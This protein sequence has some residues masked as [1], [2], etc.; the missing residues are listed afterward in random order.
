[1]RI[2][3]LLLFSALLTQPVMSY[4]DISTHQLTRK[5]G[6][7]IHYYIDK[8]GEQNKTLL[9]LLQ[10]SDCNSI[11]DNTFIQETFGQWLPDSD[12]LMVEKYGITAQLPYLKNYD[13][14]KDCPLE[15]MLKDNPT[16]RTDDYS[17]V[18]DKL[19][20]DYPNVVLVGG[21]EGATM[22][23]LIIAQ[24]KDIKAG[25]ALNG[26]GRFFIDDV[27]YNIRHTTPA[28]Y[29]KEATES[30]QQFAN[31]A[32]NS[33][34]DDDQIV[35][36]HGKYWWQQFLSIDL[37]QVIKKNTYTPTLIIQTLNDINVDVDAFYQLN[38]NIQQPNIQFISYDKLDH[39]FYGDD[40]LHHTDEIISAIQQ[41]Y[42]K[43]AK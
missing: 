32:K 31:A 22:V 29:V 42:T 21:S 18:L 15:Y 3:S 23:H 33:Q 36:E 26:G 39:G 16:Q 35:S 19:S 9:V 12:I 2:S 40:G 27:L 37:Q 8:R 24:R 11:K 7:E 6:S 43:Q 20:T 25:I 38:R 13:Q 17:A 34:M 14:R 1:M 5:D 41:W 10:G 28:E 4:A 30:F